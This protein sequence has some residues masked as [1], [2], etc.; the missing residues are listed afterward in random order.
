MGIL[1]RNPSVLVD[2]VMVDIAKERAQVIM[3]D[4]I[5]D[6][7]NCCIKLKTPKFGMDLTSVTKLIKMSSILPSSSSSR[8]DGLYKQK[9]AKLLLQKSVSD[10]A[11][12]ILRKLNESSKVSR[13]N[14]QAAIAIARQ[15]GYFEYYQRPPEIVRIEEGRVLNRLAVEISKINREI[16]QISEEIEIET[17]QLRKNRV[18]EIDLTRVNQWFEVYGKP[19]HTEDDRRTAFSPSKKV[20]GGTDHHKSFKSVAVTMTPGRLL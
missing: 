20:Y 3:S 8:L 5:D 6:I 2:K 7:W 18:R 15:P 1:P 19:I 13:K 10:E 4:K 16:D 14:L 12:S 11:S 17:R 9:E